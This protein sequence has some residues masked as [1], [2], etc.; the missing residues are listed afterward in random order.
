MTHLPSITLAQINPTVG[1]LEGNQAQILDVWEQ[2]ESDL[3]VFPE[4]VSCGYPPEDLVLKPFFLERVRAQVQALCAA[5]KG[6]KAGAIIGCPWVIDGATYNVVHLIHGGAIIATQVKY[7]LPNY[8]VFDEARIFKAGPLPAPIDFN[9]AKL[10]VLICEDMWYPDAAAHLHKHG[11]EILIVP[12]ASPFETTKGQTRLELAQMRAR[13][14]GLPLVYVNQV[15]GQD[16]L[17]FDGGSF[18]LDAKGALTHHAPL[19]EKSITTSDD[20]AVV[21]ILSAEE[22]IY[23]A[24]RLGLKDYTRKN[25]FSGVVLGLSGGIDSAISAVVACDALG[26]ENVHC[27]MMPSPFTSQESLDDAKALADTLGCAYDILPIE[28]AMEAFEDIIP[29]LNGVAHE[30]MQSRTRGLIL[31]ALS[32]SSGKMLLSTGN[33][34]EMAVGYA[35]LYGDMNGGFNVLKDVYKTQ[36]YDVSRWVNRDEE[37][38]PERIITKAP[39]AELRENQTDQDSLP[40][41]DVLDD[42]LSCLIEHDMGLEEITQRGHSADEVSRVWR[43]L[44]LAEY[45]RRQAPP[46]VKITSRSFGRDRRYSI[47][48]KFR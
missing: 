16:E 9:G 30:N 1:D 5:S 15:G 12:N 4:M 20:T 23:A 37:I 31:M 40:E 25:G 10:G 48:N 39:T 26:A 21:D 47:T 13:E 7:N 32:N 45:K 34:S 38:I 19:F 27:V 24:L 44:D 14:T 42:I 28:P 22:K 29:D 18:V 35:T 36:V 11:A 33:K 2:A 17:V 8:G 46:G 6:F 43:M 3:V 41:Y